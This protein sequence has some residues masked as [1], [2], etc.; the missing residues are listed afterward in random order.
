MNGW[1]GD[2]PRTAVVPLDTS[3]LKHTLLDMLDLRY[4]FPRI[5]RFAELA[6][7]PGS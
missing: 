7:V 5:Q 1:I 4:T 3:D 2:I 6:K